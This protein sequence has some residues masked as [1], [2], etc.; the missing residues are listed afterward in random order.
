MTCCV[1]LLDSSHFERLPDSQSS[2]KSSV[3]E[4]LAAGTVM[5]ELPLLPS[6]VA[7]IVAVP[8]AIALTSPPPFT[9][10]ADVLLETHV[11]VRPLSTFPFASR[12]VAES[13]WL[14]P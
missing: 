13:C 14:W 6:L 2:E 12:S 4:G 9:V 1:V 10:A 3:G 7:V 11:I 8:A 5:T